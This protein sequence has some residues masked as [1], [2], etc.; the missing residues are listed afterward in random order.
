MT[1]AASPALW[2]RFSRFTCL[3]QRNLGWERI[4]KKTHDVISDI[5]FFGGGD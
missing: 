5:F 2:L 1:T 3:P 4:P